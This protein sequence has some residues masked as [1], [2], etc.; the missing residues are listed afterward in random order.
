MKFLIS[1]GIITNQQIRRR[2]YQDIQKYDM[3][4]ISNA[5]AEHGKMQH[6]QA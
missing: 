2:Q 3:H 6:A 5:N 4:G 1:S